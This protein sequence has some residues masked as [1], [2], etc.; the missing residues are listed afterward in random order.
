MQDKH[1][2]WLPT[3]IEGVYFSENFFSPYGI[4]DPSRFRSWRK[5]EFY[6]NGG[7]MR[8][9]PNMAGLNF[10]FEPEFNRGRLGVQ[11]AQHRQV[12]KGKDVVLFNYRLNDQV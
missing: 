7:A 8:Y 12:A 9:G 6:L 11:Y 1:L 2:D 10:K 4:T 3:T 5:D